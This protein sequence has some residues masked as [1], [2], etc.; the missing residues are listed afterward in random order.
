MKD[1]REIGFDILENSDINDLEKIGAD[2]MMIDKSARD[3]MLKITNKK[4]KEEKEM[5][6]KEQRIGNISE[7]EDAVTGVENYSRKGIS[8]II[9]TALSSAAVLAIVC[10]SIYM[11]G[12]NKGVSPYTPEP[13]EKATTSIVSETTVN[14]TA[15]ATGTTASTKNTAA[16]KTSVTETTAA[17]ATSAENTTAAVNNETPANNTEAVV[18]EIDPKW[19]TKYD[20]ID[21]ADA[22]QEKLDA[23]FQRAMDKF[24]FGKNFYGYGK[25]TNPYEVEIDTVPIWDI[26]ADMRDINGDSVPELF[27]SYDMRG[28]SGARTIMF[29]Y[30]GND[31]IAPTVKGCDIDGYEMTLYIDAQWMTYDKEDKCLYLE[32][33]SGYNFTRKIKFDSDNSFTNVAQF[34]YQG[35]YEYGELVNTYDKYI[36]SDNPVYKSGKLGDLPGELMDA[37]TFYADKNIKAESYEERT[38][39]YPAL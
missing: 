26:K 36:N 30:D 37:E 8:R 29:I 32:D 20:S 39:D 38:Y 21:P 25:S 6:Y 16:A 22:T 31:F 27:I 10:G 24:M 13:L 4:Y 12:R 11:L 33:K 34:N 17:N 28:E 14:T 35:Y 3:R 7:N 15:T 23:A 1:N 18:T 5:L 19:I 2:S 9:Y